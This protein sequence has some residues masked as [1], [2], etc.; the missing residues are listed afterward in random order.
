MSTVAKRKKRM[1][2]TTPTA[3]CAFAAVALLFNNSLS[4]QSGSR[5]AVPSIA[6][7]IS[8]PAISSPSAVQSFA[9]SANQAIGSPMVIGSSPAMV[10]SSPAMVN[11]SPAMIQGNSV[12]T[13]PMAYSGPISYGNSVSNASSQSASYGPNNLGPYPQGPACC[14]LS[15]TQPGYQRQPVTSCCGTIGRLGVPPL[16]TPIRHDTPPVG[17]SVG[18]P[19]FGAWSGF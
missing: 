18:R 5:F 1:R 16:L 7:S 9:N 8:A 15:P 10:N 3:I 17:R 14:D 12:M 4:A 6:P 11:S 2:L 19:L 13:S